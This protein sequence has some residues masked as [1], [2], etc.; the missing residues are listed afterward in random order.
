VIA[1]GH[2]VIA[3]EI[4]ALEVR[5]SVLQIRLRHARVHIAAI[6]QQAVAAR[7]C[8]FGADAVNDGLACGHAVLTIA[9]LPEAAMV[10]VGVQD[11]DGVGLVAL[12]DGW[13]QAGAARQ[14]PSQAKG[15]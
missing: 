2:R 14:R 6:E 10:V 9:V 13:C 8:H 15:Q 5:H 12:R 11:G 4:H 7:C 3:Q 1:Y